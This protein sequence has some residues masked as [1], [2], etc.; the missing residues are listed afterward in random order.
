MLRVI[1]PAGAR[2]HAHSHPVINAGVLMRGELT[3]VTTNGATLHL[4]AGDP[5][6]EVVHTGHYGVNEGKV[7]AEIVVFYAGAVDQPVTI[8]GD[9]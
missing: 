4:R 8:V 2:L 7:P 3:V 9:H 5:I 6:V 1:V